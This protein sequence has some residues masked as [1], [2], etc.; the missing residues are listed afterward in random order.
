MKII[1]NRN[2]NMIIILTLILVSKLTNLANLPSNNNSINL[3]DSSPNT[4][5]FVKTVRS[6]CFENLSSRILIL[7][8][9]GL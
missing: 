3:K 5:C 7:S 1:K 9:K 8:K 6:K 2:N 4:S